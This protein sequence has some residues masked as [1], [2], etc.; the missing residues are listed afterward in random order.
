MMNHA[1][2]V[3]CTILLATTLA[4]LVGFAPEPDPIPTRWQLDLRPGSLRLVSVAA[5]PGDPRAYAFMTYRVTNNT[6]QD[7]PFVPAFDLATDEG[8]VLRSGQNV[9]ATVTAHVLALLNN[10][11]IE[12]QI[13]ILGTLQQGPEN[14]KDGVVIWP[15]PDLL[16]DRLTVYAAGFSGES[17]PVMVN[18]PATGERVRKTLRKVRAFRFA[19]PG[20]LVLDPSIAIQLQ[21]DEWIM[22]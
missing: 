8:L 1:F 15:L 17:K 12:D 9:P 10:E 14:A 3:L 2:R 11:F 19:T 21:S 18:D 6:G 13:G 16:T 4:A 22:R 20:N 7:L 5:T